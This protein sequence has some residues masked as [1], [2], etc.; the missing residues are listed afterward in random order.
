MVGLLLPAK[1]VHAQIPIVDIIKAGVKKVIKAIDLKI[2][3]LQ[4]ETIWLQQTQKTVENV[5]AQTKLKEITGWVEQQRDLYKDYY[6]ELSKVKSV[7]FYFK[8]IKTLTE[9][10]I[11]LVQEYKTAWSLL[12]QDKH[13]TP[14]ELAYM[15]TVY[16]GILHETE[17]NIDQIMLVINALSTQM[18]DAKRM[19]IIN[20]AADRIEVNYSD[21]VQFNQ[22]CMGLSVQRSKT[23]EEAEQVKIIY[24]LQ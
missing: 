14:Q 7:I 4:N 24:G 3:R 5:M 6:D 20:V 10:Q 8:R 12:R 21:L 2:Q 18:S 23:R 11:R 9:M 17:Q 22:Q 1:H 16:D 19:E 13:F 15:G